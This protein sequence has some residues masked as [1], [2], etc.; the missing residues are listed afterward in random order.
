VGELIID[1]KTGEVTH[2]L[3]MKGNIFGKKEV[4][5][6]VSS[7]DRIEDDTIHLKI[8]REKVNDLPSLPVKRTWDEV[9]ATD[10]ELVVWVFQSEGMADQA[11][12]KVKQLSKQY[13]LE[14]LNATVLKKDQ[15]SELH[16]HEQKKAPSKRKVALGIALGGLAGLAIG[17]VAL[18]AGVIAGRSA[19]KKSAEKVEV[20]FSAEKLRKLD[21]I[22]LPGCSALLLLVEH[23]WFIT[24]QLGL[25]E[26]GG[27][28]IHERLS[29]IT[30]EE[31]M[32]KISTAEKES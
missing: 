7:I 21:E 4:A 12:A 32:D 28:L 25:A 8:E 24:L 10:L 1:P 11:L 22:L 27:Q 17:P 16:V 2:F 20:G 31:L 15:K 5:I 3:L 18:V 9:V 6:Q 14:V 30:Y 19:G 26:N 13:K 23:R 29:N